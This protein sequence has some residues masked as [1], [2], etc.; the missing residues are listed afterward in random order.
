MKQIHRN[1]VFFIIADFMLFSKSHQEIFDF[2]EMMVIPENLTEVYLKNEICNFLNETHKGVSNGYLSEVYF[3]L[4]GERVEV[5]GVVE[6]LYACNCC[7]FKTLSE[8]YGIDDG[9]YAICD[10]CGW[11][12]DGTIDSGVRSSVN[13]CSMEEKRGKL[14]KNSNY[15]YKEK[16]YR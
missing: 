5:I 16:W 15:F 14:L 2:L 12:D 4:T 9:G 1:Q 8:K 7:G 6:L 13:R 11:E 3:T 10:Y